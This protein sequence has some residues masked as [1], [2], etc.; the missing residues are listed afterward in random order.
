MPAK[1]VTTVCRFCPG[2]CGMNAYVEGGKLYKVEGLPEDPRTKGNLCPKGRAALEILYSPNRVL[3]P[4]RRTGERGEGKWKVISWKEA[5]DE[6]VTRFKK[7][8]ETDGPR[9]IC[10]YRGQAS[11][12]GANW[13]YLF[14]FMNALGAPNL[15]SPAHLCYTPRTMAHTLTYGAMVEPDYQNTRCIVVWGANPTETNERAPFGRQIL[16][17]KARGAKLIVPIHTELAENADIWLQVR[18]GTDCALALGMLQVIVE[19]ELYDKDFVQGWTIGFEALKQHLENYRSD[20]VAKVAGI[21]AGAIKEV[22]RLFATTKPSSIFEGNGLD[23]HIN[24]VQT[25][26]AICLL[27]AI[28]GNIEVKGGDVFPDTLSREARDIKLSDRVPLSEAK[29][30]GYDLFFKMTRVV[31]PPPM[32]DALLTGEPYA[33]KA[34]VVEGANPVVTL[35]NTPKTEKALRQLEFLVVHDTLMTRTTQLSD[36]ILPA[37][38]FL[39]TTSLTAYP[40]MRTNSPLLQQKVIEPL[41]EAWPDWKIWFELAKRLGHEKDFPWGDV[42][43]AIDYQLEPTGFKANHLK[44]HIIVIPRRFDKFRETGFFTAS[45]KVELYSKTLAEY[46][47]DPLPRYIDFSEHFPNYSDLRREYPLFGTNYPRNAFYSHSQFR[48]IASLRAGDPEP[49]VFVHSH[50]AKERGINGGDMV[51]VQSPLGSIKIRSA[52]SDRL[53]RGVLALAWGW[54]EA[55]PGAGTNELVDDMPRDPICAATS[56]RLFLCRVQKP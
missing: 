4:L 53:P 55:L 33:I 7:I 34:M 3:H 5:M 15:V 49:L 11:D 45:K 6:I 50:D 24:V 14:R 1:I 32:I 54:G 28:T 2:G 46:G 21:S 19:E 43:E 18:L 9:A 51:S 41:G 35:A 25:V 42:D 36:L 44:A 26:R 30:G 10:L 56:S 16:E 27:R 20:K 38:T 52:V 47:Y 22:A 40:G 8:L 29:V 31:P 48:H 12:F 13:L 37:T 17:A 23:Q 39:E